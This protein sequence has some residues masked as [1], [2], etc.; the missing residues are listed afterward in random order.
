MLSG[1]FSIIWARTAHHPGENFWI[2]A[3]THKADKQTRL[4]TCI[5]LKSYSMFCIL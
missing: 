4:C 2:H 5:L 3:C 1:L